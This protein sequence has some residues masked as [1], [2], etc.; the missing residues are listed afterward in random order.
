MKIILM[1]FVIIGYKKQLALYYGVGFC[2]V[3]YNYMIFY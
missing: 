1:D 2:F 3:K